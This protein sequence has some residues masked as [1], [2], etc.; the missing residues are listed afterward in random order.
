MDILGMMKKAQALQAK[1]GDAQHEL[2]SEV[3]E[4]EAGGGAVRLTLSGAGD[5]R[6]IAIEP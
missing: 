6:A 4:G 5:L 1:L 3:F 2:A